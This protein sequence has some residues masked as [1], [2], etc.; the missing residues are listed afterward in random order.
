[1]KTLAF[2]L[3]GLLLVVFSSGLVFA[4][5]VPVQQDTVI[6]Y[7]KYRGYPVELV[8]TPDGKAVIRMKLS[9][10]ERLHSDE[11]LS[12]LRAQIRALT[13]MRPRAIG[14]TENVLVYRGGYPIWGPYTGMYEDGT[15]ECLQFAENAKVTGHLV[16]MEGT[17]ERRGGYYPPG[18]GQ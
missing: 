14:D 17:A 18:Y 7:T 12:F 1:M 11:A 10:G 5:T 8:I 4:Q 6:P 15:Y 13:V 3:V 2:V 16:T 9:G